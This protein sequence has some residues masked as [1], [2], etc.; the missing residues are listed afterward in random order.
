[1]E[2]KSRILA[3]LGLL[4]AIAATPAIAQ[5]VNKCVNWQGIVTYQSAPCPQGQRLERVY[6]PTHVDVDGRSFRNF[7]ATTGPSAGGLAPV[8]GRPMNSN[9]T[10]K[11]DAAC[12][13]ART[14]TSGRGHRTIE[15]L[16]GDAALRSAH[17]N[18]TRGPTD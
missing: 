16:A 10:Q 5:N 7:V 18:H 14:V 8:Y 15:S 17:C 1:M 4:T 3:G 9:G 2:S 6:T 12:G 11:S 13:F